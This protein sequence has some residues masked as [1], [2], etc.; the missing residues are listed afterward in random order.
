MLSDISFSNIILD[1][2]PKAR[3]MKTKYA[4][5]TTTN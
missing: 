1:M 2:S 5:G 4:N 3:E